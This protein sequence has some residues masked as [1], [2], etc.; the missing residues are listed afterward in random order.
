MYGE[1]FAHAVASGDVLGAIIAI[2]SGMVLTERCPELGYRTPLVYAISHRQF[3]VVRV[4]VEMGAHKYKLDGLDW[5]LLH[6]VC[7]DQSLATVKVLIDAGVDV[8][9]LDGEGNTPLHC[10]VY[11]QNYDITKFLLERGAY[12]NI[13][14]HAGLTA[15]RMAILDGTSN[16]ADLITQYEVECLEGRCVV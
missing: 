9:L 5:T 8:N 1:R 3:E 7:L 12:T 13:V 16:I 4:L 14:S 11:R 6:T 2:H 10:A 15:H